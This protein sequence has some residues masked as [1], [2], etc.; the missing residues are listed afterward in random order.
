MVQGEKDTEQNPVARERDE[1]K[2]QALPSTPAKRKKQMEIAAE[3]N[4]TQS[5]KKSKG[6]KVHNNDA[7]LDKDIKVGECVSSQRGKAGSYVINVNDAH[8]S[9]QTDI[10]THNIA[11]VLKD[12]RSS[13]DVY[14]SGKNEKGLDQ[15][16]NGRATDIEKSKLELNKV[17][18]RR[19]N[20]KE[21]EQR[22]VKR[23]KQDV[24]EH[25]RLESNRHVNRTMLPSK[26]E[27]EIL[28]V[29]PSHA[30]AAPPNV[31]GSR[32][33]VFKKE[34]LNHSTLSKVCSSPESS[35][36]GSKAHGSSPIESTVSSSPVWFRKGERER[37]RNQR[38]GP[39]NLSAPNEGV[40]QQHSWSASPTDGE[41]AS[42]QFQC[43]GRGQ[44]Q[45]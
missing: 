5:L 8:H 37:S 1:A 35:R 41:D 22:A 10:D 14:K 32:N 34:S 33:E 27:P 11:S 7:S 29:T 25:P 12:S 2:A 3:C 42:H 26:Q 16:E 23:L 43:L 13:P 40:L 39:E 31:I 18:D 20:S 19:K 21:D 9:R 17:L 38:G 45:L 36:T 15:K 44:V 4:E 28:E 24:H 30:P 6:N